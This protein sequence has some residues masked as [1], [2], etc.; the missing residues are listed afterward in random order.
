MHVF[1][2]PVTYMHINN[3]IISTAHTLTLKAKL[4]VSATVD[5]FKLDG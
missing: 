5:S 4:K 1:P 3:A 2:N